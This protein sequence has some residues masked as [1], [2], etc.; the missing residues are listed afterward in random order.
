MCWAVKEQ[1]TACLAGSWSAGCGRPLRDN[2]RCCVPRTPAGSRWA[3]LLPHLLQAEPAS[4]CCE[5]TPGCVY[6]HLC[7]VNQQLRRR[8]AGEP[9]PR[10]PGRPGASLQPLPRP[11][12]A[13]QARLPP[14]FPAEVSRPSMIIIKIILIATILSTLKARCI[15]FLI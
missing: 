8:S 3:P 12:L 13:A 15:P 9:E 6:H 11:A 1:Q 10:V 14:P 2:W 4:V 7:L 5:V